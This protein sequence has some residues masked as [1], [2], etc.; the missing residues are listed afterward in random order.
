VRHP[1]LQKNNNLL[2]F[3]QARVVSAI[4]GNKPRASTTETRFALPPPTE[5]SASVPL[6]TNSP[7]H[8]L[9]S[10]SASDRDLVFPHLKPVSVPRGT[11]IY[12]AEDTIQRVYFPHSGIVSLVVGLSTGQFVEAGM[13]GRNGVI[14]AGA[15]LDGQIA[16]NSAVGQADGAGTAIEASLLKA[17]A[18]ESESLRVALVRQEQ[19]LGAQ[20][21]QVAAC[22]ALHEL[23]ERLSRWLLQSRD[24]LQSDTLPLTQEFLSQMLGVQRS[25]VTLVA[26]KLQAAGLINYR[27][28]HIHV[29]DVEGLHDSCCEC[30]AAINAH[31]HQRI[32]WSPADLQDQQG[33]R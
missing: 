3:L 10:L 20:T 19:V 30:Y 29:L 26:R 28:G 17:A 13:L 16:L 14:G 9:L 6:S 25:S 23:E 33:V 8:F 7:N 15:A 21:Q 31:F 4:A 11:I 5:G 27:R 32:G 2:L 24:L 22:N 12:K 18:K 1:T